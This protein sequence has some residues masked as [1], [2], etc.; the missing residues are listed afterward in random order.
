[1]IQHLELIDYP[2]R[3][4]RFTWSNEREVSKQT[5][6]DRVMVS[7][8]WDL[9]FPLFQLTPASS[10]VSDHYPLML[11]KMERRHFAGFRFE[12][13]WLLH[14]EFLPVI[15]AAWEKPVRSNDA[16]RILHTKLG[17]TAKALRRWNKGLTRWANM[18]SEVADEV[19]FNLDV[20]QEDWVLTAEERQLR[21]YLKSKLLGIAAIDRIKWRQRSRI[22]WIHEG[23]ANTKFFHLRANG[24]RRKNHIPSLNGP[25]GAV[26]KHEEKEAL[27]LQHFRGLMGSSTM[28]EVD[29]NWEA[30][31]INSADLSHL[32]APFSLEELKGA[33][34]DLHAE[35]APGPDSFVGDFFKK[36]WHIISTD[37]LAAMNQMHA[38]KG[39]NWRL[40]NSASIVLL[41]KKNDAVEAKDY[42]PVS[43]L[44][45]VTKLLCK[46]MANRLAPELH[47][48]VSPGQSAFIK[49]RSIQ[50]NFLYV[51]NVIKKAHKKKSPLLFLKLDIAKAVD[52]LNWGFLLQVLTKMGFGQRWHNIISLILGS[53]S[54]RIM[55]NGSLGAPFSHKRGLRQGDP[56]SPMLFILAMEPL[57]CLLEHATVEEVLSPLNARVAHLRA[58]FYADDA[59]LFVNTRKVDITATQHILQLFGAASGLQTSIPKCVAFPV[60]CEGL[61]LEDVL[62]DFGRTLGSF[63]CRYLGLPLGFRKPKKIE[64]QPVFYAAVSRLKG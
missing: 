9:A 4:R 20:A 48:L 29:I 56:L 27:L 18:V 50:D 52:S 41:P 59:A 1:L 45:S 35:K 21:S 37:L 39:G 3:G 57:Q 19:I 54:S 13:H 28:A 25:A 5:R 8:E 7:K 32:D 26:T 42:R 63:P 55:L 31:N 23:D 36:C 46:M 51:R 38:L 53:S 12:S 17:R 40:L 16:L 44:H 64:V 33:V 49:G 47:N 61:D 14:K 58:S 10:N 22:T 2:L 6:I 11:A 24:R 30:L 43:L 62:Q 34:N 15:T 60:A